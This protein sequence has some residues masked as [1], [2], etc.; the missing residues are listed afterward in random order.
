LAGFTTVSRWSTVLREESAVKEP[1]EMDFLFPSPSAQ[2]LTIFFAW[3]D[4]QA[5]QRTNDLSF[6]PFDIIC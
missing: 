6:C 4:G 3:D 5:K 2:R 1:V